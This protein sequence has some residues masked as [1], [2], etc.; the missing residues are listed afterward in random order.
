MALERV[1]LTLSLAMQAAALLLVWIG[2]SGADV[3]ELFKTSAQGPGF[4]A[5]MEEGCKF[6]FG[7]AG[8][9][10]PQNSV[11]GRVGI[12]GK[13]SVA[14]GRIKGSIAQVVT[15]SSAGAHFRSRMMGCIGRHVQ[16]RIAAHV[17][18]NETNSCVRMRGSIMIEELGKQDHGGA[19]A[20]AVLG[21]KGAKQGHHQQLM[22]SLTQ[23]S[24]PLARKTESLA[25]E[26]KE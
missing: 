12:G 9:D 18:G 11:G 10:C 4:F 23:Q 16:T 19:G 25:S 17:A 1:C 14:V 13:R 5:T 8:E 24:L 26:K 15:A 21:G 22:T 20:F 3:L 2:V 6:R 7:S